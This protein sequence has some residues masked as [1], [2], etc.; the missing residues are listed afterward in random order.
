LV[1]CAQAGFA[2][3]VAQE[4]VQMETIVGLVAGGLGVSLV[5]PS[6]ARA[7]RGGVS[8]RAPVGR[9]SPINY[10]LALAFIR[11]SPMVDAF[12]ASVPS[13]LM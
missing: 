4:A 6:L 8:F 7:G 3:V 10:D 5:P 9:G 13:S 11:R 1:A 2:P 12:I